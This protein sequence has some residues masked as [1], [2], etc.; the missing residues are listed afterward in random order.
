MKEFVTSSPTTG[1]AANADST[2]TATANRNGTDDGSFALTVTNIDA[3]RYKITGTV[4]SGYLKGDVVNVSVAAT[5]SAVAGKAVVDTFVVDSK[6]IG[7]LNDIAATAVVSNGAI[8]TNGSGK[9]SGVVLTDTVTTYTDNTPQTG[10]AFA[11]IGAAGAGLTAVGDTAG[12]TSLLA[13]L[14]STRATNLDNLDAGIST[15]STYAGA[16]TPG[17]T[18]LLG[19]LTALRS[20]YLDNL[21]AGAVALH[22]DVAALS[23]PSTAAIAAAILVTPAQKLVTDASGFVTTSNPATGGSSVTEA[24]I[25]AYS[26]RALTDKAGFSASA[27]NLPSDYQQ[28]GV[29]VTLPTLPPVTVGANNDKAG[30]ALDLSQA[31]ITFRDQG[32]VADSEFT[33]GDALAAAICAATGREQVSDASYLVKSPSEGTTVRTFAITL[34]GNGKPV[35]RD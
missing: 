4:P 26:T 1:A 30:Y 31:G 25:W 6:R 19:R 24:T 22:S 34:N 2:P 14:T 23:I 8:T 7:D 3:G 27:T 29:A 32:S 16:D 20:G 35:A 17:T 28:R 21:S 5:C 12:T 10:D 11:R 33:V 13:R 15:R 9:V 18:T